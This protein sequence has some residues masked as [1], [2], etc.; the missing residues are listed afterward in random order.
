MRTTPNKLSRKHKLKQGA[1]DSTT[2]ES[3]D[4]QDSL[5]L[6]Q[7]QYRS[8]QHQIQIYHFRK[9]LVS[10]RTFRSWLE[11]DLHGYI[12]T[13][14][15]TDTLFLTQFVPKGDEV[16]ENCIEVA[17]LPSVFPRRRSE[18]SGCALGFRTGGKHIQWMCFDRSIDDILNSWVY[19]KRTKQL[20]IE[21]DVDPDNER[22]LF[23]LVAYMPKGLAERR[24]KGANEEHKKWHNSLW[25][26]KL[27]RLKLTLTWRKFAVELK[28][29]HEE[30]SEG[31]SEELREEIECRGKG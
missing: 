8:Y 18:A 23:N 30:E 24:V 20:Y 21:E 1:R 7:I 5:R 26:A 10:L 4:Y 2:P 17:Y 14:I 16:P 29:Y 31:R 6:K 28:A 11:R 9:K 13:L 15:G 27:R 25:G 3:P 22:K 19:E 12:D